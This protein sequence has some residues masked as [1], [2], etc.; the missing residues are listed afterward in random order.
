MIRKGSNKKEKI[1]E[2][3]FWNT[4]L[5]QDE[6]FR[7]YLKKFPNGPLVKIVDDL[8]N[9]KAEDLVFDPIF[10]GNDP[11]KLYEIIEEDKKID[12]I[13]LPCPTRQEEI[14]K[15]D[16]VDEFLGFLRA[17]SEKKGGR[18]L[19][20]NLQ[21]STSYREEARCKALNDIHKRAE[22]ESVFTIISLP[23]GSEFYNQ[24]NDYTYMSNADEFISSAKALVISK[25]DKGFYLPKEFH[26]KNLFKFLDDI[27]QFIHETFYMSKAD[28]SKQERKDFLELFYNFLI[29]KVIEVKKPT[30]LS[31]SCKDGVDVG[32]AAGAA[33]FSF[34]KLLS[35]PNWK[36]EDRDF[37]LYLIYQPALLIRMRAI[38]PETLIRHL[39]SIAC[40]ETHLKGV[41]KGM[42]KFYDSDFLSSL[43]VNYLH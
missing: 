14:S 21:D 16:I 34:I 3:S 30:S 15:A 17:I 19:L 32:A 31:F 5:Q 23:K 35:S 18:H 13:H 27:F 7:A 25:A 29:L 38:E 28:L 37:L 9:I 12:V 1:E 22:F 26:N 36:E 2:E 33:F 4:L 43:K 20:V 11:Q 39:S 8:E 41:K 6:N 42:K 24:I 10:Q 40:F